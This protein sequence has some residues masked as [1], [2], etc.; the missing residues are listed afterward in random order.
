V[1]VC[2]CVV[3]CVSDYVCMCVCAPYFSYVP[4]NALRVHLI[5]TI[6]EG[7]CVCVWLCVCVF[8][9]VCVYVCVWLCVSVCACARPAFLI[10]LPMHCTNT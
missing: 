3:V 8:V 2:V 5:T 7:V 4:A 9:V 10:S 6:D 1:C